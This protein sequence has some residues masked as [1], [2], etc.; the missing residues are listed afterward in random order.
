ML[1][2]LLATALGLVT[3]AAIALFYHHHLWHRLP[4]PRQEQWA[5]GALMGSGTVL[6]MLQAVELAPGLYIDS[7]VL[8]MGFAGLLAGWRGAVAAL[9]V[10]VSVRLLLGGQGMWIGSTTLAAAALAGLGWRL[11][12]ARI[13]C[14][15]TWRYLMFS[16]VLSL[17]LSTIHL[18]PEPHRSHALSEAL[19]WL[20]ALNALGALLAGCM[21]LGINRSAVRMERLRVKALTDELTGLGNRLCLTES[22]DRKVDEINEHGGSFALISLDLDNFRHVNDTLGHKV[23]DA[24]L[25]EIAQRLSNSIASEDLLVR[26]A[27]DQFVVMLPSASAND[28]IQRAQQLLTIARAPIQIDQYVLLMTASVGVVWS[29]ENG[30]ESRQLLQNAEIAMYRSKHTGRNQITCFDDNMRAVL[31]RQASL[32][33]AL[34]LALEQSQGLALVFQPQFALEDNRLKGAEVLLRWHHPQLGDVSPAEFIPIAEE[35]GLVRILDQFVL[36]QA[37]T[38]QARWMQQGFTFRLSV[39]LS[40]LSLK[41]AN[42]G[43]DI[44][45][46][47]A[48][49]GVPPTLIEIEVT[50]SADLENS[51]EALAAI[52]YLRSAGITIALDDFGTGHSSL[53]Y[54]QKL[55]LD[56]VK[57]DRSFV[58]RIQPDD[59]PSNSI[60]RAIIA[61]A[62]AL[63]LDVVAEG[64]ETEEQHRWLAA[65]GC[66]LGQGYLLG[67]PT[68]SVSFQRQYLMAAGPGNSAA[69][70]AAPVDPR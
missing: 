1:N 59:G 57:I 18:F 23:G 28:V 4:E 6:V 63:E 62:R 50:E 24:L 67:R 9:V 2:F 12:E 34:L 14:H 31:E 46:V 54:L 55:P 69:Q 15:Q 13:P 3:F 11:V 44:L 7:R 64:I 32:T 39:N 58:S 8:L 27:G 38:Q 10:A 40:V 68:D 66:E 21:E 41:T 30:T 48:R 70:K 37:A 36:E 45:A 17:S 56:I 26:V 51:T 60:L 53:S 42:I 33:Q 5:L 61:L 22:I 47:L 43:E 65:E 16:A 49:H 52:R 35:A 29:P 25:I 19:P 20:M